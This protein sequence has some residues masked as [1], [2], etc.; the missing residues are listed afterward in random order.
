M[1]HLSGSRA[2]LCVQFFSVSLR[3]ELLQ[4]TLTVMVNAPLLGHA[5]TGASFPQPDGSCY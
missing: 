2:V 1:F 4:M 3:K 5:R